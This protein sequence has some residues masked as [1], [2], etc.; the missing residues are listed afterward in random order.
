MA[1]VLALAGLL[2]L[3]ACGPALGHGVT[4]G[5][6]DEPA[7]AVRFGYAG[8]EPMSYAEAKVFGPQSTPD[9]EFQNGRTDARG[10]FAFV[11]D[12]PRAWSVEA[13]DGTGHR[14]VME[15]QVDGESHAA[16]PAAPTPGGQGPTPSKILLGLSL[17][18]NL[19]LAAALL[20]ARRRG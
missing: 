17:L 1:K 11:P 8:G 19:A 12:R 15:L 18:A 3:L 13:N 7:V 9:L 16:R 10:V 6:L 2:A 14:A 4:Y 5:E 20:R